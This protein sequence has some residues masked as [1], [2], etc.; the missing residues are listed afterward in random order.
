MFRVMLFLCGLILSC[1]ST[2][3]EFVNQ[4]VSFKAELLSQAEFYGFSP[5]LKFSGKIDFSVSG[6]S[7]YTD[8]SFGVR[9][10]R[11]PFVGDKLISLAPSFESVVRKTDSGLV[12]MTFHKAQKYEDVRKEFLKLEKANPP[13]FQNPVFHDWLAYKGFEYTTDD[14]I[15]SGDESLAEK[16]ASYLS[17]KVVLASTGSVILKLKKFDTGLVQIDVSK[18]LASLVVLEGDNVLVTTFKSNPNV[19]IFD[20][21]GIKK[22]KYVHLEQ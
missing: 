16:V 6:E 4:C 9:G 19:D 22:E 8:L 1:S 12:V 10:L 18:N 20:W 14:L 11:I 3:G 13:L 2:S 21:L 7:D 5:D 17:A 15:C